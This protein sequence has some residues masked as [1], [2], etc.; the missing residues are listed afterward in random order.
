M[1]YELLYCVYLSIA[2]VA[3]AQ[4]HCVWA[5]LYIENEYSHLYKLLSVYV[6]TKEPFI[7]TYCNTDDLQQ[8]WCIVVHQKEIN[9][10]IKKRWENLKNTLIFLR[11]QYWANCEEQSVKKKCLCS[12]GEVRSVE[13]YW[14][15]GHF[16][17]FSYDLHSIFLPSLHP[18]LSEEYH[19]KQT[20]HLPHYEIVT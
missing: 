17:I 20:E 13:Q 1:Y 14:F 6:M 16:V 10:R 12:R 19:W 5:I 4:F 9:K 11:K 7:E 3:F 15:T 18:S 2:I 8:I